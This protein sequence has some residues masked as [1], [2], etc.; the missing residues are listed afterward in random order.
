M[1]CYSVCVGLRQRNAART[2]EHVIRSALTLF[3]EHGF[4]ATTMEEIAEAAE[5]GVSTLYRYFPHKDLLLVEPLMLRGQAADALSA[6]PPEEP[7]DL[8]LGHAVQAIV[9]A[10]RDYQQRDQIRRIVA[11]AASARARLLE[12]FDLERRRLAEAIARR[13][14][15]PAS[16]PFCDITARLTID[17]IQRVGEGLPNLP[18]DPRAAERRL[19]DLTRSVLLQLEADP[20]V[21]PRLA[22]M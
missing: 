16:D 4:E 13:L 15:R 12:E 8:A 20:P 2:R 22:D 11:T 6:R 19:R 21:V 5:I 10:P 18:R 17:V 3:V 9:L 1:N 7:L 14:E